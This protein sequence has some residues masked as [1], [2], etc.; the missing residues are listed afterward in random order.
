MGTRNFMCNAHVEVG[1]D[2]AL[3]HKPLGKGQW[4]DICSLQTLGT[5]LVSGPS[6][7]AVS[8]T[9][10]TLTKLGESWMPALESTMEERGSC[11]K[12]VETTSSAVYLDHHNTVPVD[13]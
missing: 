8:L 5:T 2:L 6:R 12:S 3:Q 1:K 11:W 9:D 7:L 4:D 13:V 10:V